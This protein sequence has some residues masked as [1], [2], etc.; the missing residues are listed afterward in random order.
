VT[1]RI[2]LR[3][4]PKIFLALAL[5]ACV[6][7][8]AA[9]LAV[10]VVATRR[11]HAD[12]AERFARAQDAFARLQALRAR[13]VAQAVDALAQTNPQFRT[14]LA[15]ASLAGDDLGF[16][17]PGDAAGGLADAN[18]RLRSLVPSLALAQRADVFVVTSASGELLY[19]SADPERV[20]VD[21]SGVPV[22]R[23]AARGAEALALWSRDADV[24]PGVKLAPVA[25]PRAVYEVVA[26]PV[27]FGDEL[28]GVVLVGE[29]I[30]RAMLEEVR[31]IAAL[32]I[33]L[34]VPGAPPISTLSKSGAAGLAARLAAP[35][36]GHGETAGA[37]DGFEEWTL[38][39]E[40]YLVGRAEIARQAR[41]AASSSAPLVTAAPSSPSGADA[42]PHF[43]LFS[44]LSPTLAFLRAVERAI[45]A[46]G[47]V[48]LAAALVAAFALARGITEP[49]GTL[50]RAAA[51]VGRG[52]LDASV[53]IAS[54]DELEALGRSFNQMVAGLRERDRIRHT[55][56]RHV[57]KSV[58]E[59][60]LRR[61]DAVQRRG[62]RREVSVLF[63][64]LGGFSAHAEESG[65]EAALARLNEYFDAV[66][67]AVFA[68]EGTVNELLGDGMLAFFGA[69]IAQDDHALRACLAALRCR[70]RLE[71]LT[72]R[73]R[74]EGLADLRFRIGLHAGPVIVGE[75]GT[76]ER[77]KYGA[78]GDTVNLASRLEGVNRVYGTRILCSSEVEARA[79][80]AI[81]FRPIDVVRVVGRAA[82]VALFEPLG[83][84]ADVPPAVRAAAERYAAAL[85]RHRAGDFAAAEQAF[86]ALCADAPDD[87]PAR[88]LLARA[89][90]YRAAPPPDF[91]GTFQLAQK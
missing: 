67:E 6:S 49:V 54:G 36:E 66:S 33:A 83:A 56:E 34:A 62:E 39:G 4:R 77:V 87:A 37:S 3:L 31:Q 21:L 2:P 75:M 69:P 44:S 38:G 12:A 46:V 18:L 22:L 26:E 58:A 53:A 28:H 85:A 25:P 13:F 7:L 14:V 81:A 78:I 48:V 65:P 24:P 57:S 32:E 29:R 41:A 30:D 15:T 17:A 20:G 76:R 88:A 82:P 70:E 27:V 72:A 8:A 90:A 5:L 50:A 79:R 84:I 55:F 74:G 9:L 35:P 89:R 59:E 16:G 71:A 52:E 60:I 1:V 11:A 91:D 68:H 86:A 64:D 23:D 45:L 19:A 63:V 51:R 42:T 73:W 61:P 43:L 40:R 80:D 10:R 47:A